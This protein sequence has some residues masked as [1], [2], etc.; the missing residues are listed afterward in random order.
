VAPCSEDRDAQRVAAQRRHQVVQKGLA[1][2]RPTLATGCTCAENLQR[3]AA[4]PLHLCCPVA[5]LGAGASIQL[6]LIS[7]PTSSSPE[8]AARGPCVSRPRN[9]LMDN[10]PRS[11]Q[12]SRC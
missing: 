3:L 10:A 8:K 7:A 11:L 1:V 4:L 6:A 9:S 2:E 5:G 12:R